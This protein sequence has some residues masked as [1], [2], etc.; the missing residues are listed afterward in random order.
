MPADLSAGRL[1][2]GNIAYRSTNNGILALRW[3]DRK[4][5]TMLSTM[6]RATMQE[7]RKRWDGTVEQKPTCIV[8]YNQGMGGVDISDQCATS[9]KSVRKT[10]KWHR[11]LFFY[12]MDVALKN[13]HFIHKGL[14]GRGAMKF[15]DFKVEIIRSIVAATKPHLPDYNT[16]TRPA[17]YPDTPARFVG[18]HYA[19]PLEVVGN[20]QKQYRRCRHCYREGVVRNTSWWCRKCEV[21]LCVHPCFEEQQRQAR[22]KIFPQR[23]ISSLM[24]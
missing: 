18:R 15:L 10:T 23:V 9:Y 24:S 22:A 5:V 20:Q 1:Q 17:P 8:A 7:T 16:R 11:M 19:S 2:N 4:D 6:H 14:V 13:A 12:F 21:P 3:A